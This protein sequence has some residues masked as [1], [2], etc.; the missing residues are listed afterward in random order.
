VF[1][2]NGKALVSLSCCVVLQTMF[3]A[4]RVNRLE[5]DFNQ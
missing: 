4:T 5:V 1:L 2:D 3:E